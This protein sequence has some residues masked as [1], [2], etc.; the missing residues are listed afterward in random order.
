M[1][2]NYMFT[3]LS[4]TKASEERVNDIDNKE[5]LLAFRPK[6][7]QISGLQDMEYFEANK[8]YH[9]PESGMDIGRRLGVRV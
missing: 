4:I 2:L 7:S 8:S 5:E 9:T 6:V 1:K 3:C